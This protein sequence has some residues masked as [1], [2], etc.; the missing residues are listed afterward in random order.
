LA[1][2]TPLRFRWYFNNN[3]ARLVASGVLKR[4]VKVTVLF[5]SQ[6]NHAPRESVPFLFCRDAF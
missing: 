6:L 2:L 1:N 4:N 5:R 3:N